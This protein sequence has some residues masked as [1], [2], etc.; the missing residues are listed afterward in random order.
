MTIYR[1]YRDSS[2]QRHQLVLSIFPGIDLLGRAFEEEGFCIVRGP[3]ILWGGDIRLFHPP[4][5]VFAGII[6]GP[7]CPEFSPLRSLI[8]AHGYTTRHGNLIPE[9]QRVVSEA[10][11]DWYLMEEGA[12]AP[13]APVN[14]YAVHGFFLC[15]TWLGEEQRRKRKFC[16]GVKGEQHIDLRQWIEYAGLQAL[17]PQGEI[18]RFPVD[19]S[20]EAKGRVKQPAVTHHPEIYPVKRG[21]SG[22]LKPQLVQ[23][24]GKSTYIEDGQVKKAPRR[25]F[26]E[27]C[28]LQGL[29]DNFL[30][31]APFTLTGKREVLGNGVPL[32]MGRAVARAI[33]KATEHGEHLFRARGR[34][35]LVDTRRSQESWL[36]EAIY[37]ET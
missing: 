5:G 23:T 24:G 18:Y 10:Q 4:V 15:P 12:L 36:E 25:T 11:P 21:G 33:R 26:A 14:G 20:P 31:E 27:C 34:P 13:N 2:G 8:K 19:N 37:Y 7:P 28:R 32:Q 17:E 30:A 6:G 3:D 16:F 22:K 29:P 35:T 9:F 1:G